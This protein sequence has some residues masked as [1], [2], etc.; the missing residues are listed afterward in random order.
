MIW[1]GIYYMFFMFDRINRI[2]GVNYTFS[3]KENFRAIILIETM[4]LT[5]PYRSGY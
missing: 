1:N 4:K 3:G 2:I 5:N